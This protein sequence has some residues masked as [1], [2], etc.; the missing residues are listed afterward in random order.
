M[1]VNLYL[2]TIAF[3]WRYGSCVKGVN[4]VFSMRRWKVVLATDIILVSL[5]ELISVVI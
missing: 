4:I 3:I 1:C 5:V 2:K